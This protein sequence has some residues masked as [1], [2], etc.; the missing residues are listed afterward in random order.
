MLVL[1]Y[2]NIGKAPDYAKLKSL[3]VKPN[4]LNRQISLIK[5]MGYRFLR[6][7]QLLNNNVKGK[8]VLLT[9]D[10]AYLDFWE[11]ALPILQSHKALAI[12]FVPAGLI[13]KYNVWDYERLKVKKPLMDWSHLKD[14]VD[15]GIEIGSH[16]L[17]HPFLTQ[18]PIQRAKEEIETSKKILEDNLGVEV[19][20]FCYPYGNYNE[21]VRDMVMEAGY[22]MAF[23]TKH[24]KYEDSPNPYEIRRVNIG[25]HHFLLRFLFKI[26]LT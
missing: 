10:D 8:A 9:F 15:V 25:G 7:E 5:A 17:T 24:G 21:A 19:K 1:T 18:I 13:G 14:L 16:S 6:S 23:T 2:H 12:V 26:L 22:S 4:Q 20:S 3:Y 11:K